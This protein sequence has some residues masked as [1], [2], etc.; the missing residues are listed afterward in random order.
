MRA[1][2]AAL[3][4]ACREACQ[5][6]AGAPTLHAGGAHTAYLLLPVIPTKNS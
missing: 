2:Q 1:V 3:A 5:A 4:A 6:G